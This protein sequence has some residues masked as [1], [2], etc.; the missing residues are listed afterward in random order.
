MTPLTVVHKV[1]GTWWLG[2]GLDEVPVEVDVDDVVAALATSGPARRFLRHRPGVAGRTTVTVA[3][4]D[5]LLPAGR[6]AGLV[7]ADGVL[8]ED[9][10]GRPLLLDEEHLRALDCIDHQTAAGGV[11]RYVADQLDTST[12]AAR[13]L[14][15][16]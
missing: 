13:R 2:R 10:R 14:V 4:D 1:G 7:T 8:I 15:E 5:C 16:D 6:V 9:H 3:D 12:D 11:L